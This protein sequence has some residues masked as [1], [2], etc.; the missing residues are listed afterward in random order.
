M[1]EFHVRKIL[2]RV[3]VEDCKHLFLS[4][5]E[6]GVY[7]SEEGLEAGVAYTGSHAV[8]SELG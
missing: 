6:G 5:C 8:P 7:F 4:L 3:L 2:F 1:G